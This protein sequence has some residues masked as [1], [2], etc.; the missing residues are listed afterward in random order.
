M[1]A[2]RRLLFAFQRPWPR[3]TQAGRSGTSMKTLGVSLLVLASMLECSNLRG[4]PDFSGKNLYPAQ[5]I[6]IQKSTDGLERSI[7]LEQDWLGDKYGP[8]RFVCEASS[9]ERLLEYLAEQSGKP[10]DEIRGKGLLPKGTYRYSFPGKTWQD[11]AQILKDVMIANEMAFGLTL[12]VSHDD[13][14]TI[15][16]IRPKQN[17]P[18]AGKA[19]IAPRLAITGH[20]P[21][22]PWAARSAK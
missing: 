1:D 3:A 20:R 8:I 16:T 18:A 15:L 12:A 4:E 14:R 22:V 11:R 6:S 21:G 19:G 7:R 10:F 17:K 2:G 5:R 13:G 9:I